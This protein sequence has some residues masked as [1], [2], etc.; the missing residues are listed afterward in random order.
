MSMIKFQV[1]IQALRL[2]RYFKRQGIGWPKAVLI[3]AS[4]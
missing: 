4:G 2:T 3:C 1:K